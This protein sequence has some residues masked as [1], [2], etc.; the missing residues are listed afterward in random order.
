M[1]LGTDGF[2]DLLH[3]AEQLTAEMDSGTDLP[4]VERN[5]QQILETGQR[6]WTRTAQI[7]QDATDVKA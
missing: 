5:L 3:Q 1:D 6:L 4:R 2:G 7:S